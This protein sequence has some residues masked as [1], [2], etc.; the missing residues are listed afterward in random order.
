MDQASP[1][2]PVSVLAD[3]YARDV[4][5]QAGTLGLTPWEVCEAMANALG[6][7]LKDLPPA[8]ATART[9]DLRRI[10]HAA[11]LGS[12]DDQT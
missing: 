6:R 5:L 4:N 11:W 9:D 3:H 10:I 7:T 1:E 12:R 8:E 2:H